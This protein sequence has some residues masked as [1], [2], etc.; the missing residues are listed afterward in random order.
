ML[1]LAFMSLAMV[2]TMAIRWWWTV[3]D[4][5]FNIG[6]SIIVSFFVWAG[7]VWHYIHHTRKVPKNGRIINGMP[8]IKGLN[9]FSPGSTILCNGIW[10]GIAITFYF[11]FD[12]IFIPARSNIAY[13]L[14]RTMLPLLLNSAITFGFLAF[15][16]CFLKLTNLKGYNINKDNVSTKYSIAMMPCT[17]SDISVDGYKDFFLDFF[18][19]LR[20]LVYMSVVVSIVWVALTFFFDRRQFIY[21]FHV[22]PFIPG[23]EHVIEKSE[24]HPSSLLNNSPTRTEKRVNKKIHGIDTFR[25]KETKTIAISSLRFRDESI[26]LK[27]GETYDLRQLLEIAPQNANEPLLWDAS[28]SKIHSG[29]IAIEKKTGVIT[30]YMSP[31][32]QTLVLVRSKSGKA[33]A[34]IM[35]NNVY[36]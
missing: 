35:I 8:K 20:A 30:N 29:Y 7:F 12:K 34:Q 17:R 22:P 18:M 16:S 11:L 21:K 25:D 13:S 15:A 31:L 32:Q 3:Q 9:V 14:I 19:W 23:K 27:Y 24:Q 10:I 5:F 2:L 36:P 4:D 1:F 33:E 28:I 6:A 26:Q